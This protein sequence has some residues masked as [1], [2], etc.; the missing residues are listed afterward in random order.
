MM[1]DATMQQLWGA[2]RTLLAVGA[3]F[4]VGKGYVDSA[5]AT[6]VIGALMTIIPFAWSAWDKKQSETKTQAR[7][8]VAVNAGIAAAQAGAVPIAVPTPPPPPTPAEIIKTY[9]VTA[10]VPA[11][12]VV[13]S[14]AKLPFGVARP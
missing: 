2:V 12:V 8:A 4:L 14:A 1:D 13:T 5:T 6:T 10:Q 3:G 11:T 7:E 9:A